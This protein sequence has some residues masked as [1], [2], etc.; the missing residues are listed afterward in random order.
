VQA[1]T[2]DDP[3][4]VSLPEI[5]NHMTRRPHSSPPELILGNAN[6]RFSGVT[7]TMLQ[8]LQRNKTKSQPWF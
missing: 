3:R 7:S 6:R 4:P 8:V 2:L 5:V 1:E